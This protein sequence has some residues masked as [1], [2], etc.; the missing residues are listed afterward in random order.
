MSQ[1][2]KM[3]GSPKHFSSGAEITVSEL[4]RQ[5]PV[6]FVG[7]G[8]EEARLDPTTGDGVL[9]KKLSTLGAIALGYTSLSTWI[10]YSA[11][12]AT[13]L[14]SGGANVLVWGMIIVGVCNMAAAITIAEPASQFPNASGQAAW[15]YRLHGRYLSYVT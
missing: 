6:S 4:D 3:A 12:A 10:A 13:A 1:E 5:A 11:S 14:A 9:G 2:K 15:V 7:D 8:G